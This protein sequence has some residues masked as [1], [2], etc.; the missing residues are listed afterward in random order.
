MDEERGFNMKISEDL[1]KALLEQ[2]QVIART[3]TIVGEEFVAGGMTI[4]PVS[5]VSLGIGV[6]GGGTE[7]VKG[8]GGGG[9]IRVEPIAF[10]VIRE[11]SVS[12]L[13]VGR[14]KGMEAVYEKIPELVDKI[15]EK[16]SG[17]FGKDGMKANGETQSPVDGEEK[18]GES[19]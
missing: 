11:E 1:M 6:G 16:V 5:R 18:S 13:N 4:I 9:G 7:G 19:K 8:N 2:M 15:V 17:R 3:E 14:G 10:L 12:L